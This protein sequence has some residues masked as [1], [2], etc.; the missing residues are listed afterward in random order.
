MFKMKYRKKKKK[1][2]NNFHFKFR[3]FIKKDF[4]Y[5]RGKQF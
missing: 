1:K 4:N 3:R 5:T 2:L